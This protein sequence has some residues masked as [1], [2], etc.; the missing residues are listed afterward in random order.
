[1]IGPPVR[2]ANDAALPFAQLDGFAAGS[3]EEKER[4]VRVGGGEHAGDAF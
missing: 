1:M 3:A 2:S 4:E